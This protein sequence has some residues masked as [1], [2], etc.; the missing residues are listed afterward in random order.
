MI[1][2]REERKE[3]RGE[4]RGEFGLLAF[5]PSSFVLGRAEGAS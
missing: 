1:L 5:R 3:K 4:E 2:K